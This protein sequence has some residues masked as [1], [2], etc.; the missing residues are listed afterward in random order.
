MLNAAMDTIMLMFSEK[1]YVNNAH[2]DWCWLLCLFFNTD[3][4]FCEILSEAHNLIK[5][6]LT[7]LSLCWKWEYLDPGKE[8]LLIMNKLYINARCYHALCWWSICIYPKCNE[9]L[10]WLTEVTCSLKTIDHPHGYDLSQIFTFMLWTTSDFH[11]H[12]R[13]NFVYL[14]IL[15]CSVTALQWQ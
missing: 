10:P 6:T 8:C 9:Q 5:F 1:Y 15:L 14:R 11:I 2:K 4:K 13:Y 12:N 3:P 7:M